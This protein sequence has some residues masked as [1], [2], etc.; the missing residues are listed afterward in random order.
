MCSTGSTRCTATATSSGAASARAARFSQRCSSGGITTTATSIAAGASRGTRIRFTGIRSAVITTPKAR[1]S[2]AL[3]VR[4]APGD[5]HIVLASAGLFDAPPTEE[6][7]A[8]FLASTG[9]HLLVALAEDGGP[10]GFVS[11]VET[12]HP[13]KGT[14]MFLYELA[15]ATDHRNRGIGRALVGALA[16]LARDRGCYGM[17]VATE[18]DNAAALATYRAAGASAPEPFVLLEWVFAGSRD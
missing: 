12:T 10:V 2:D 7:A 17:W 6:G 15:V 16:E 13:D 8:T 18:P 4:L 1:A 3:I 5:E 11:G 14:E 9:H